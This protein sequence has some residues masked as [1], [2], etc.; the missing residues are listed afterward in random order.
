MIVFQGF[1]Y[2]K[3]MLR[4]MA[5]ERYAGTGPDLPLGGMGGC[6]VDILAVEVSRE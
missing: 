1:K 2:G 3:T 6:M 4:D 5:N